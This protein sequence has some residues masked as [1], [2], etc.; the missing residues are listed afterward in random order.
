MLSDIQRLVAIMNIARSLNA[1]ALSNSKQYRTLKE[2]NKKQYLAQIT[3]VK[4]IKHESI[5]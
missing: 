5:K 1:Y 3:L 4:P 2:C